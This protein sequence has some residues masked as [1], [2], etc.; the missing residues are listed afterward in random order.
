MDPATMTPGELA[1]YSRAVTGGTVLGAIGGGIGGAKVGSSAG[2]LVAG[3][4]ITARHAYDKA[5]QEP[6]VE[7]VNPNY[8]APPCQPQEIVDLQ[9]QVAETLDARTRALETAKAMAGQESKHKGNQAPLENME[10]ATDGEI[11][12]VKNHQKAVGDKESANQKKGEK[13]NEVVAA[14][15]QAAEKSAE[16]ATIR[17]PMRGF[18]RFTSLA[19]HLDDDG[20]LGGAKRGILKMNSDSK[21]FLKQLDAMDAAVAEQKAAAPER[22]KQVAEDK[23]TLNQTAT[24]AKKSQDDLEGVKKD[25]QALDNENQEKLAEATKVKS[26]A[27]GAASK[28]ATE[29]KQKEAKSQSLAAALQAW[30]RGHKQ[31][32][33]ASLDAT[34]KRLE[35]QGYKILEVKEL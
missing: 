34:K 3:S 19:H 1:W 2:V 9:N 28:L 17:V 16:T 20:I 8:A 35:D 29:A 4:V 13:E 12:G 23:K 26:G 11:G 6:I 14:V 24:G 18:E 33:K 27:D 7:H 30:A 22:A 10:K 21:R 31:A 25:T 32:R 15:K 5:K